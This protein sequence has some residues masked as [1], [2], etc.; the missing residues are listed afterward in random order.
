MVSF[1]YLWITPG[2]CCHADRR[3]A[4]T[5]FRAMK[6]QISSV[7]SVL[8]YLL[9]LTKDFARKE[10][11]HGEAVRLIPLHGYV[12][13]SRPLAGTSS[14]WT[15]QG[16]CRRI[17]FNYVKQLRKKLI[18]KLIYFISFFNLLPTWS[19]WNRCDRAPRFRLF[20]HTPSVM[21][22]FFGLVVV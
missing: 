20:Y 3:C 10:H 4:D 14:R 12:I 19:P 1:A 6:K 13:F 22:V 7:S 16:R 17:L 18:S 11:H 21:P 8:I 9:C 5:R 15:G 2:F